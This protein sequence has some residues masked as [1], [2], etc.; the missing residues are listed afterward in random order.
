VSRRSSA[1]ADSPQVIQLPQRLLRSI[2]SRIRAEL[3]DDD[4][5]SGHLQGQ[6]D[7]DE[8][9]I[10]LFGED[11]LG[12]RLEQ[13]L[14]VVLAWV[15]EAVQRSHF[16]ADVFVARRELVA[17]ERQDREIDFVGAGRASRRP[18]PRRSRTRKNSDLALK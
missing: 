12:V 7:E 1:G 14:P 3:G 16:A 6:R 8:L 18:R 5:L 11:E 17:E 9:D 15:L 4:T 2:L 13:R 10:I